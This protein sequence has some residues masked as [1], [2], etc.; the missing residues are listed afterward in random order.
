MNNWT[1]EKRYEML[2]S[3]KKK[4]T[5][6]K[7]Q[8]EGDR[9][10][11]DWGMIPV[12]DYVFC[13]DTKRSDSKAMG[14]L[15]CGT[16]F[17]K[18]LCTMPLFVNKYSSL[19]GGYTAIFPPYV[20]VWDPDMHWTHLSRGIRMY[21]IVDGIDESHHFSA[22]LG[23]GLS[24]GFSGLLEKIKDAKSNNEQP[25]TPDFYE[26]LE[27]VVFGIQDW[28]QRHIEQAYELMESEQDDELKAIL[29]SQ[30]DINKRIVTAPP[31]TFKEAV[32]WINWYVMAA[33]VYNS[34]G[35]LGRID[36]LLYPYYIKDKKSGVLTDEEATFELACLNYCDTQYMQVGGIGNDGNDD[37]NEL[38]FL[39]LDAVHHLGLPANLSVGYHKNIDNRLFD[40]A[41]KQ[42]F[43]DR[44]G[45]PRLYSV[46]NIIEGYLKNGVSKSDCLEITQTGCHWCSIPGKTYTFSDVIKINFAKVFDVA[47]HE[48]MDEQNEYS[49]DTL[50]DF[51][52]KHLQ[53]AVDIVK[54]GIDLHMEHKHK[55]FPELVL[56]LCCHD[57]IEKGRD[58]SN[59]G[60]KYTLIGVD[61]AGLATVADSFA[62][63]ELRIEK[64]K[65]ISWNHML[66]M[67][68]KDYKSNYFTECENIRMM[69]KN[70][71]SYGRVETA[72]D[73][74]ARKIVDLFNDLTRE[75][76]KDGWQIIPGLFSWADTNRFGKNVLA[77]P[78]GRKAYEPISFGANPNFGELRGGGLTPTSMAKS[79][80]AI[81]PGYGN[82]APFQLDLD[83][84]SFMTD[85]DIDVFKETLKMHFH[86][87][88]TLINANVV[89]KQAILEAYYDR[90]K[91]PDLI[92]RVTGF[93]A[94]FASLSPEFRKLVYDRVVSLDH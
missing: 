81:Q 69:M 68:D 24:L 46:E 30:I 56:D 12:T 48:M 63:I 78:D 67:V 34:N 55:F 53:A 66:R 79:I 49:T 88:G 47:L 75:K 93:C 90:D 64:E 26:S 71:P 1:Y 21:D 39:M 52:R 5:A 89:D 86:L 22:D 17:R 15:E 57:V 36:K 6:I 44:K 50:F 51:F 18:L 40:K 2:R 4:N 8:I 11:D 35:A 31:E 76:T 41:V 14:P 60:L 33:R 70:V 77:T 28:I 23:I 13:P 58:A 27:Q 25:V 32:S 65:K 59:G 38:S 42:L 45:I 87:G 7:R 74:W 72:G 43:N 73:I 62:A 82:T 83:P 61:G 37:T 16:N 94:Y 3:I 84:G 85:A 9:D 10:I 54:S 80:A 29:K 19:L 91:Y 92:V 20:H